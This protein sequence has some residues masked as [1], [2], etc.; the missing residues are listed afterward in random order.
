MAGLWRTWSHQFLLGPSFSVSIELLAV[1]RFSDGSHIFFW[2][3]TTRVCVSI[4]GQFRVLVTLLT[5]VDSSILA[6]TGSPV[7]TSPASSQAEEQ[8]GCSSAFSV[9][10]GCF[11]TV[12]VTGYI[13]VTASLL[14]I[15]ASLEVVFDN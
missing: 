13:F 2:L 6:L 11:T 3:D 15:A 8:M 4:Q 10:P 14:A 9:F 12:F 1:S 5:L 7:T